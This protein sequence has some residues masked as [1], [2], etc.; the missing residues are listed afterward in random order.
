MRLI[1]KNVERV[2]EGEQAEKLKMSGFKAVS[3][4]PDKTDA[5]DR[6]PLDEM[7]VPE[8][9]T[10]AKEKDI[11]GAS[12]LTKDELLEVLKGVV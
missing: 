8:L 2:A 10:L 7:T 3:I 1:M 11:S 6:K 9:K 4:T 12:S 5:T